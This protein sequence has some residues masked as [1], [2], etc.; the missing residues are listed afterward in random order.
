MGGEEGKKKLAPRKAVVNS[1]KKSS[2]STAPVSNPKQKTM[3]QYCKRVDSVDKT[4][5]SSN[6]PQTVNI[7]TAEDDTRSNS[8]VEVEIHREPVQKNKLV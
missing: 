6:H 1:S 2:T 5:H 8:E 7:E 3:E 4:S